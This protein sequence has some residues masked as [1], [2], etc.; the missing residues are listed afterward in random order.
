MICPHCQSGSCRRSQRRGVKDALS[1]MLNLRPW[2]CRSCNARFDA[3]VV[4]AKYVHYAHCTRCGNLD[5]QRVSRDRV[6]ED[7][8]A[9]VKRLLRIP[10]YRCEP[11]RTRFFSLRPFR[12]IPALR[13]EAPP[14]ET[15]QS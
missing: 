13:F 7:L 6:V 4:P 5:L 3:W 1:S 15:R 12:R 2:R 14:V 9:G 10:A 11:C 8:F